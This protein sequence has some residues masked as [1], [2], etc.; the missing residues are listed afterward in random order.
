ML[1]FYFILT[2]C[3]RNRTNRFFFLFSP[4][5]HYLFSLTPSP[6]IITVS[7]ACTELGSTEN[8]PEVGPVLTSMSMEATPCALPSSTVNLNRYFEPGV[9]SPSGRVNRTNEVFP[10]LNTVT[11]V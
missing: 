5:E 4:P 2:T 10:G 8:E 6:D 1:S 9:R 3:I 11:G 7:S